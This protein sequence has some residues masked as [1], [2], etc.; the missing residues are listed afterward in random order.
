MR[1]L[2]MLVLVLSTFALNAQIDNG[3]NG[4][5]IP[6]ANLPPISVPS[7]SP[8]KASPSIFDPVPSRSS[9]TIEET[10]NFKFLQTNDFINRGDE[11]T[12]KMNTNAGGDGGDYKA[13]RKNQYFGDFKT[14]SKTVTISYRD[15]QAVDGDEVR[16]LV[17]D[18][19]VKDRIWLNNQM[20]GFTLDLKPGF[21]KI[22]FEALNQGTSG[23]NTAEFHIVDENGVTISA[24]QW[25]LAT[26]FKASVIIV[27]E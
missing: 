6:P 3:N 16:V 22:D 7:A 19:I 26:G 9:S 2:M 13:F 8:D 24:R 12:K 18:R 10:S 17:N 5:S 25:D 11:F 1:L 21:N 23:P 14:N 4:F 20:Q 27:K 15:H